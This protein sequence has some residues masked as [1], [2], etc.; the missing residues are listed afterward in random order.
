MQP[1]DDPTLF[2]VGAGRCSPSPDGPGFS[3]FSG[4]ILLIHGKLLAQT[5]ETEQLSTELE[6]GV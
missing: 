1:K 3:T 2:T 6:N 5:A 4:L